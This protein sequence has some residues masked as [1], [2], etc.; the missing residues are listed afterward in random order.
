MT[1]TAKM[2]TRLHKKR[3]LLGI[4]GGIAAYKAAELVRLL[5]NAGADVKVVLSQGAQAFITPLT[6]QAL[7]GQPVHTDLLDPAA[8]AGMGHIELAKWAEV[9][10]V[11]PASASF[12]A[13]LANGFADDLLTTLCL[14]SPAPIVVAPAM[15]QQMWRNSATQENC[16]TLT[17]RSVHIW[18]PA[19]GEQACGDVGPGRLLEP[20]EL[21]ARLN[22]FCG[23]Q[24]LLGVTVLVTA[25]PTQEPL[26][27]VRFIGNRSSGKMG[28]A[29]AEAAR[30]AG[31]KVILISGP[32]Q[33]RPPAEVDIYRVETAEE[34]LAQ[35]LKYAPLSHIFI[36]AAA[37]ADYRS[38]HIAE[39]K[40]K[41]D[42]QDELHLELCKNPDIVASIANQQPRPFMVG[43]A[44]ETEQVLEFAKAKMQRKKLDLIVANDVSQPDTGFNS[45]SN[46]AWLIHP[47]GI[48][49]YDITSK[50]ELAR[51]LI[52]AIAEFYQ[53]RKT[54]SN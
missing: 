23:P 44:A 7:S 22:D 26:D 42:T 34:M 52:H 39:Q 11:A 2:P 27:P 35:C 24:P 19:S 10:L 50:Q 29:L 37:V 41:K 43:F 36:G 45:D 49:A 1:N 30:D 54:L 13:R 32:T 33:I 53:Q 4:T 51:N 14:A 18:G 46:A 47:A 21:L 20:L 16:S 17:R 40:I 15:N 38:V 28:Y 8:E 25:G 12:I 3:I 9:I 5:R 48:I 31:A 6:L